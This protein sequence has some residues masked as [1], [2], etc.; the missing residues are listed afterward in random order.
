MV[1]VPLLYRSTSADSVQHA[2]QLQAAL[3]VT[4]VLTNFT[5]ALQSE[6]SRPYLTHPQRVELL[7]ER[8][9]SVAEP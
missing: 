6:G 7:H 9:A 8:L 2:E 1:P 5:L 4:K 3:A